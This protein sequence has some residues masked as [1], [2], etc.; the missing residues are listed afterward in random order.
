MSRSDRIELDGE[1][2]RYRSA[3]HG[4][5]DLP[6]SD[7]R[8]IGEAT[9]PSRPFADDYFFCFATGPRMWCEAF[10]KGSLCFASENAHELFQCL[11]LF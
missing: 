1:V 6:V 2:I 3:V 4:D 11:L 5:W 7:V 8:I 9:N 10:P